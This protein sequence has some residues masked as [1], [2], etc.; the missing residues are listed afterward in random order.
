MIL[1]TY[2]RKLAERDIKADPDQYIAAESLQRLYDD[3]CRP[4]SPTERVLAMIRPKEIVRGVYLWGGVG[5]GKSMVIDLFYESLPLGL[6]ARRVHFHE[7]MIGVHDY[8]HQARQEQNTAPDTG[9]ALLSYAARLGRQARVLCFD[10]FHVTDIA[11]AML[12]SRLFSA[13]I[14][15]HGVAVVATSNWPPEK[16]YEHGLQ[17]DRFL[18]FIDLVRARMDI[19][20]MNGDIDYRLQCL[21]QGG[22]Y[23][24]PLGKAA[25]GRMDSLFATL[26]GGAAIHPEKLSVKGRDLIVPAAAKGGARLSFET[27][28]GEARGA[29]DYLALAGQYHTV[30]VEDVPVMKEAQRNE[31]KRFMALV[32]TLY[33]HGTKLVVS[34]DAP[35][36][37]LYKGDT[38]MVEFARTI[39]RLIEMQSADYISRKD[40]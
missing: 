30:L 27:L 9:T 32:D 10:E 2:K 20:E 1:Q 35:P 24:Y 7:F 28:C 13:L 21:T 39:S 34:A 16:L 3:L 8:L 36:E 17:R 5:R 4:L 25:A 11:D 37:G 33:D 23:F 40:G 22:V 29:G 31:A 18:P 38:H 15:K 19:V 12:L 26:T 6:P 14:E